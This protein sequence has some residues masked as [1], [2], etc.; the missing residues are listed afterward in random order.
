LASLSTHP[1]FVQVTAASI[2][3]DR[4]TYVGATAPA[5][6]DVFLT[7]AGNTITVNSTTDV[8][9][10][11]DGLCTLREAITAANTNTAS[12][13]TAGECAAGGSGSD[14]ITFSITGT[15]NLASA[16]PDI[17]S[18]MAI[19]GPA[20]DQMTVQHSTAGG[21]PNFR[22]FKI[23]SG[24]TVSISGLTI[25]NGQTPASDGG[26]IL[27]DQS[28]LDLRNCTV[29]GNSANHGGGIENNFGTLSVTNSTF[30]GNSAVN[31]GG[32]ID[33]HS[34]LNIVNST[35]S[36]NSA[37][38]GGAVMSDGIATVTNSTLTGNTA[39]ANGGGIANQPNVQVGIRN[40]IL[41]L[42]TTVTICGGNCPN[43]SPDLFG[44]FTSQGHN[45][46]G[47]SDGSTGF[48]NGSNGDHVG[49]VAS[50]LDPRLGP[51]ANNGG[52]TFTCALLVG[53]PALDAGSNAISDA[54]G[55]TTDQ[56]GTGFIRKADSADA[57]TT[58]IV[59]IGAFEARASVEDISDKLTAED[60]PLSFGFNVGDAGLITSVTASSSNTTLVPNLPANI[61]VT[62]SGSTRTLNI[63]PVNNLFGTSTI[64]ITVT[65]GSE[66]MS[67]TFVLTVT[68]VADTPSV[69]GTTTNEDTQSTTGLVVSRNAADGAEVTN[70]KITSIT[71]GRL[72]KNNGTTQINNGDFITFTEGNAGLK[73]TPAA[74][75]FSPS[76]TPFSFDV[77]AATDGTGSGLS[78]P[79]TATITVTPIADTPLVTPATT[80]INT[81]TTSGLVISR[82]AVD[83]TEVTHF[84]IT[85]I[86]NGTLFKSDGTTQLT[87]NQFITFTEGNAG[88][89][90]TPAHNL[91]SPSSTFSFQ[92]QGATSSGG[93][94]LSPAATA[95]I[96]VTCGADDVV[97][98]TNDS[99]AGSLRNAI[100]SACSGD[101]IT[102]AAGLTSGGAATITLTGGELPIDKNLTI[103]GP[104]ANLLTISGNGASR[105]FD[106]QSGTVNISGLM[107]ANGSGGNGGGILNQGTLT[108]TGCAI[109]GNSAPVAG[110]GIEN[111]G[112]NRTV[113][114]TIA[115][116]TISG[117]TG[118]SFGA[119]IYNAGFHGNATLNIINSAISANL[120]TSFG[121]GIY[122]DGNSGTATLNVTNSTISGNTAS[123]SGGGIYNFG[124]GGTATLNLRNTIISDNKALN[125]SNGPDIL[126]FNGT[127][128]GSNNLI[129]TGP[130]SGYTISG[131][132]NLNVDPMLEKDGLGNLI[133]KY[134]GGP[135]QTLLLLLGSPAINAGSNA[136]AVDQNS[137]ALTT[138]QRGPSFNRV[139]NTTV[140]IGAFEANYTITAT[141]GTPQSAIINTAFGIA[142]KAT[143]RE[144]GITRSGIP[145]T[146]T[147]PSS[148]SSGT[149]TGG[150]TTVIVNTDGSGV[151]TAPTFTANGTAGGPYNVVASLTGGSPFGSFA[152]TNLKGNQAIIF[153]AL[154]NKTF[155]DPP[156]TVS[157]TAS[158]G[159][160]VSFTI[161]S[162]PATIS[163]NTVTITGPGTVTVRASQAG[164]TN[165]NAA[166]QVDQSFTVSKA[167]QTI[168]FGALASKMFGDA[169]FTVSA[170]ASSGL[171]ASFTIFSG[172]ATISGNTVTITGA[173]TVTVRASQAGDSNYN[174]A[175]AVDQA[176]AV[177]KATTSTAVSSSVN[178]SAVGQ[179]VTFTAT[180]TSGAG[181]PT[182]TVQFKDN[183]T[184]IGTSQTLNASGQASISTSSLTLGR[185]M[186]TADYSGDANFAISTGE[187]LGDQIVGSVIQ[188]S[189]PNFQVIEGNQRVNLTVTRSGDTTTSA[190]V[191][192]ATIDDA[193]LT[194]CNVFNSV[195]SPRCDYENTIGTATWAAGDATSKTF[196]IAIVD[197]SYVEGTEFFT[198]SLNNP[199][200]ATLGV[201]STA[202]VTIFDND[203]SNGTNPIDGTDFFVR[204]QYLDFLGREPDPPGLAG[205]TA[206]INNCSGDTTQCDRIHVSQLFFQSQEFQERGYF[207][208]RF[209]PVAFGR[210]PDYAEFVPDLASVS[211]FLDANQLEAAKLAFIA[212]FMARPAFVSNYNGLTNQQYVDALVNTAGVS[213]SSRQAMIDGLNNSTM[214][215]GQVL[216]QIVES[217]EVSNKYTHQ[218]YAVMEYFGYLRRQPDGFYLQWISV[219]DTTND[220]RG[221]VTGFVTSQEYRNRFGP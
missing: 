84:K 60:T 161:F 44:D 205:W 47:K 170:A 66:S 188:F 45:L 137:N 57:D 115:N 89:K 2:A 160:A 140:D 127:V 15:I 146:F 193:G 74:N 85:N 119:G 117:N 214:T 183:G 86:T 12:G 4:P 206:T 62:G 150:P 104:G 144:S 107:I 35:F 41:A 197:D 79:A 27:N 124:N 11:S 203:G 99:G 177:N 53:S 92:V 37:N 75:L 34:T 108:L 3:S 213:L 126:N 163:G 87:N 101:T 6:E 110:G 120:N 130:G 33:S 164:D 199:S 217:V 61:N 129:Q 153:N 204:Q 138:D 70:F 158:S 152:L 55:L 54:A 184:L 176:F 131:S 175:T 141:A 192:F 159:L 121:G 219:L 72:F 30:T 39:I 20:A 139:V 17:A 109:S 48:T 172:P 207:V 29:S 198:I 69:T 43:G 82:N 155:G 10:S 95:T 167:N 31:N 22:I 142:L 169:P 178:R 162:G 132:N 106:V 208:Y 81:Q 58:Q 180:V 73:F 96:T 63:T 211:G 46:I 77:Q 128:S 105:I 49:S 143:V 171:A 185:H 26:G 218:A 7:P 76:T 100:N 93:A 78:L 98:N 42:N 123:S 16:F 182:G 50:P 71:N 65:S 103:N 102:F 94:G 118:P 173:G 194:N 32:G 9:N 195:A 122:N 116:S 145:V 1:Q 67:D 40:S 147:A 134:N 133:L 38:G 113:T 97:T 136:L 52:P 135:T 18:D 168:T 91:V 80:T 23:N 28:V 202:T 181:T 90:F 156:F 36:G 148:G 157:A 83:S 13:V 111:D 209:Y 201:R 68:A 19:N 114:L 215:R 51:L 216:R 187:L 5:A 189:I 14:T 25:S 165:Y 179:S 174:A 151:A 8:A 200:G 166:T 125:A 190:S 149:F 64:T 88:L 221:M 210:K 21:T 154:S 24:N 112:E 220:A 186:I 191:T 196:S 212:G 59:D 56:R